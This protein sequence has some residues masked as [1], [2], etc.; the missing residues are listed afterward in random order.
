M[1]PRRYLAV[2]LL[3]VSLGLAACSADGD[4]DAEDGTE[5]GTLEE[6]AA[7]LPDVRVEGPPGPEEA[8]ERETFARWMKDARTVRRW[9]EDDDGALA[10]GEL[11]RGVFARWDANGDRVLSRVEWRAGAETWFAA[12][13]ARGTWNRWDGD[14]DSAL[15]PDEFRRAFE[16]HRLIERVDRNRDGVVG[17]PEFFAWHFEVFDANADGLVDAEE[18][19]AAVDPGPTSF[20]R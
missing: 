14:G 1:P 11:A 16:R 18:R 3:P 4:A 20:L 8:F 19:R 10:A 7:S 9:D 12:E 6:P 17:E 13:V 2:L 15:H 5:T